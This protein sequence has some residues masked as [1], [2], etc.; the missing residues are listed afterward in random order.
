MFCV[1]LVKIMGSDIIKVSRVVG[2]GDI[3]RHSLQIFY[4]DHFSEFTVPQKQ[5]FTPKSQNRIVL[6]S[7]YPLSLYNSIICE[8]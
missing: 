1:I 5:I 4:K 6:R 7:P 2:Y 3:D 8:K